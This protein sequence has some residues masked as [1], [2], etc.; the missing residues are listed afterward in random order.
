MEGMYPPVKRLVAETME[1]AQMQPDSAEAAGRLGMVL[2]A[3]RF[4]DVAEPCFER[5]RRL[6][7]N[8]ER[9]HYYKGVICQRKKDF[10]CAAEA[11]QRA[12]GIKGD[13]FAAKVL[14][15][16]SLF[17]MGDLSGSR[18]W[19]ESALKDRENAPR[20]RF[21]LAMVS[22]KEDKLEAARKDL[23]SLVAAYP[24]YDEAKFTLGNLYRRQGEA[25]KAA[26]LVAGYERSRSAEPTPAPFDDPLMREVNKLNVGPDAVRQRARR[27]ASSGRLPAAIRLIEEGL[28]E[29]PKQ[30][31][32]HL[33]LVVLYGNAEMFDKAEA[34]YQAA[35]KTLPNDPT[36]HE[37]YGMMQLKRKDLPAAIAAFTKAI[38]AGPTLS[39]ARFRLAQCLVKVGKKKEAEEQYRK[40]LES[41][42]HIQASVDLGLL[43]SAEGRHAEALPFLLAGQDQRVQDEAKLY[44]A[45]GLA[46][47]AAGKA[48]LAQENLLRSKVIAA[49]QAHRADPALKSRSSARAGASARG[50]LR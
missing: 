42:R 12:L 35:L 40:V 38:E 26:A 6:N 19:F 50:R 47:E 7:P 44:H 21:G 22:L 43:L 4:P 46:Y 13:L 8:D 17:G 29:D 10:A 27:L 24:R 30:A 37:A 31:P 48:E 9:W 39:S 25:A 14:L 36:P 3:H 5:A 20:P 45:L 23:E 1:Q 16:E 15:G 41:E 28:R 18:E 32:F 2:L 34:S 33:D 11:F 49:A